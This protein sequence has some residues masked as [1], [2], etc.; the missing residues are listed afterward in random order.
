MLSTFP[1]LPLLATVPQNSDGG[2]GWA[3]VLLAVLLALLL[4]IATADSSVYRPPE[5]EA[6]EEPWMLAP[7]AGPPPEEPAGARVTVE[8]GEVEVILLKQPPDHA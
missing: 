6:A 8:I 2:S 1:L 7:P 4:C 5:F 3:Y